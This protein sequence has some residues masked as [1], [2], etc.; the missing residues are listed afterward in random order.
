MEG[1]QVCERKWRCKFYSINILEKATSGGDLEKYG[2]LAKY[3]SN[4]DELIKL[5]YY[6]A[7]WHNSICKLNE[8]DRQ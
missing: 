6:F 8:H 1:S 2:A 7:E 3:P 4:S 5:S